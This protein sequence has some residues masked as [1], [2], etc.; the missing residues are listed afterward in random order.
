[1][2][3]ISVLLILII[4]GIVVALASTSPVYNTYGE[5][6]HVTGDFSRTDS[7]WPVPVGKDG[8]LKWHGL[9]LFDMIQNK[10]VASVGLSNESSAQCFSGTCAG[11]YL[12][13]S[14]IT[15]DEG[16]VDKRGYTYMP[17]RQALIQSLAGAAG[18]D[19]N[20]VWGIVNSVRMDMVNKP[21]KYV[22]GAYPSVGKYEITAMMDNRG[23]VWIHWGSVLLLSGA[24]FGH[25]GWDWKD[26]GADGKSKPTFRSTAFV[27]RK[28]EILKFL[29]K[30]KES[31]SQPVPVTVTDKLSVLS[32]SFSPNNLLD[33][34]ALQIIVTKPNNQVVTLSEGASTGQFPKVTRNKTNMTLSP[35]AVG[36]GG[37]STG[38]L[39]MDWANGDIDVSKF[40][41]PTMPGLYKLKLR[42]KDQYGRL[43][44]EELQVTVDA[45]DNLKVKT[46]TRS[47]K[48]RSGNTIFVNAIVAN[49]SSTKDYTPNLGVKVSQTQAGLNI[50]SP[51]FTEMVTKL[52]P[53]VSGTGVV[54]VQYS[55]IPIS[56]PQVNGKDAKTFWV[57]VNLN[58][59]KTIPTQ[60]ATFSDNIAYLRIDM[61][62]TVDFVAVSIVG[63][64]AGDC[65][66]ANSAFKVRMEDI[67]GDTAIR[68]VE[69]RLYLQEPGQPRFQVASTMTAIRPRETKSVTIPWSAP[70]NKQANYTLIGEI[71]L[72][73][74]PS[75]KE[76]SNRLDNNYVTTGAS[77]NCQAVI[78]VC[79]T[80]KLVSMW[81]AMRRN[82]DYI[83]D[84]FNGRYKEYLNVGIVGTNGTWIE[85]DPANREDATAAKTIQTKSRKVRAGQ[86]FSFTVEASYYN[87]YAGD[88]GLYT[89]GDGEILE[90]WAEF[91]TINGAYRV[92]L[93]EI[94]EAIATPNKKRF[95]LPLMMRS[96]Q[97]NDVVVAGAATPGK[98]VSAGRSFYVPFYWRWKQNGEYKF[99]VHVRARGK[100]VDNDD[101]R[102]QSKQLIAC[103]ED[104]VKVEGNLRD[105]I[106]VRRIDPGDPFPAPWYQPGE[107]S[108]MWKGKDDIFRKAADWYYNNEN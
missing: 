81:R 67:S 59:D 95:R 69:L 103:T 39:Y 73:P 97:G 15:L 105:E 71:N 75:L 83:E 23:E 42:A 99:S 24:G 4:A 40:I 46:L 63:G 106:Y 34:L 82:D 84:S 101:S 93:E 94:P 68:N 27:T 21:N 72:P 48:P 96:K 43:T 32:R 60:E 9:R 29:V 100:H 56:V 7:S 30:G 102:P 26:M 33:D 37:S 55:D 17:A 87:D 80:D 86:G 12:I 3:L 58:H 19:P 16:A 2:F 62:Q 35:S 66:S 91:P 74:N 36:F 90:A 20:F 107:T 77:F 49:E 52:L 79:S 64:V 11:P 108:E 76:P 70:S 6:I 22:S 78:P 38:T 104:F 13:F 41:D 53:K 1:M 45:M 65:Q 10:P 61:D 14:E 85:D 47:T 51:P 98:F 5:P 44:D 89:N 50:F 54:P 31:T 28:P 57:G 8:T 88:D 92:M 18:G 25:G